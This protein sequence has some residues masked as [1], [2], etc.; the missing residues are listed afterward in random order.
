MSSGLMASIMLSVSFGHTIKYKTA[1][2]AHSLSSLNNHVFWEK[3]LQVCEYCTFI[4]KSL[5]VQWSKVSAYLCVFVSLC[6][7]GSRGCCLMAECT[8]STTTP[9]PQHGR[10][11]CHRGM[12][13]NKQCVE[14]SGNCNIH[15][16]QLT[17][18]W[19]KSNR[20]IK[21]FNLQD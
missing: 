10:D 8:T 12:S 2:M 20:C 6:L 7:A 15:K 3:G 17:C 9:K 19:L 16:Y 14:F 18:I 13:S 5:T 11:H 21:F 1:S 4:T